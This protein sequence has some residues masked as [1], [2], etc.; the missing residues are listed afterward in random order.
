[1]GNHMCQNTG[2]LARLRQMHSRNSWSRWQCILRIMLLI[3]VAWLQIQWKAFMDWHLC[4]PGRPTW[5][6]AIR[7]N[8]YVKQCNNTHTFWRTL[9][10]FGK[11]YICSALEFIF[12]LMWPEISK[13]NRTHGLKN[14]TYVQSNSTTRN[15]K[16]NKWGNIINKN[17]SKI[18]MQ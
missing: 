4:T 1:M 6:L 12:L 13:K 7:Y 11:F 2:L 15:C 9:D 16:Y 10:Q 3:V 5:P 17:Y 14:K 18:W 8:H